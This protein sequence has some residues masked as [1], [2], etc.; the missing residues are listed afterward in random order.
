VE[1][2]RIETRAGGNR[3]RRGWEGKGKGKD[4]SLKRREGKRREGKRREGKRREGKRREEKRREE[5]WDR[6]VI[7]CYV[8]T[9]L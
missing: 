3:G 9:I 8:L 2:F 5:E 1:E 4:W 6:R 7:R